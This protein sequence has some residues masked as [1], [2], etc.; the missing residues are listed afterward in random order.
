MMRGLRVREEAPLGG[1][2]SEA[3]TDQ[4]SAGSSRSLCGAGALGR[5]WARETLARGPH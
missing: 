2:S 4:P 3:A 1:F 5:V